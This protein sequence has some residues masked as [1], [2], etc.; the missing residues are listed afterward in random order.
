MSAGTIKAQMTQIQS[1]LGDLVQAEGN[2]W[3]AFIC[4]DLLHAWKILQ[5]NSQ[6]PKV[7]V[8]F[9]GETQRVNFPGGAITGRVDRKF[10]VIVSRGRSYSAADRGL[11]LYS[12]NQNA[13]PLFD[14]VDEY[15]DACR[16]LIFDENWCERPVD[17]LGTRPF[18]VE[19]IGAIV[20]AY[21]IDFQVGVQLGMIESGVEA[22]SATI[23]A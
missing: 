7:L 22:D 16:A 5:D 19:G 23:H 9:S 3:A 15:R 2:K 10:T 13:R 20:D 8:V 4:S 12:D 21:A 6:S 17:Y 11:P 18:S 14:I 1:V